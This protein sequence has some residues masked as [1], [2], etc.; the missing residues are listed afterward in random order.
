MERAVTATRSGDRGPFELS[1]P[2]RS[3]Q[4]NFAVWVKVPFRDDTF[5]EAMQLLPTNKRIVHRAGILR[6]LA[7]GNSLD[8]LRPGTV[9]PCW[10]AFPSR[11]MAGHAGT[12]W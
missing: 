9:G 2:A 1:V 3:E 4:P 5:V 8:V 11:A 6:R 10:T 7:A 12:G